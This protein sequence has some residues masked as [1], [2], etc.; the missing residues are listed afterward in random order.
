MESLSLYLVYLETAIEQGFKIN[1]DYLGIVLTLF[2][3]KFY[4][5]NFFMKFY[6]K[7]QIMRAILCYVIEN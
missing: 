3:E 2:P 6:I 7:K 1:K 5:T 4:K